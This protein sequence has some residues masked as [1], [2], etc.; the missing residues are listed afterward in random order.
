MLLRCV[1]DWSFPRNVS[2][3]IRQSMFQCCGR[4]KLVAPAASDLKIKLIRL[5][6]VSRRSGC[7]NRGVTRSRGAWRS[8]RH[9]VGDHNFKVTSPDYVIEM[10]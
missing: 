4:T 5:I 8:G 7:S 9:R 1:G 3:K 2:K 6:F 10:D